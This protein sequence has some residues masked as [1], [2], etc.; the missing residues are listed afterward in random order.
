MRSVLAEPSGMSRLKLGAHTWTQADDSPVAGMVTPTDG[1]EVSAGCQAGGEPL[2]V[3]PL[4]LAEHLDEERTGWR[5]VT[6]RS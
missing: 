2:R 3:L 5:Q 4:G 1:C 6:G